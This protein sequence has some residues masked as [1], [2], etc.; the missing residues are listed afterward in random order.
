MMASSAPG[1]AGLIRQGL[2]GTG[3][4]LRGLFRADFRLCPGPLR[5]QISGRIARC[6]GLAGADLRH[7]RAGAVSVLAADAGRHRRSPSDAVRLG[8]QAAARRSEH[9][10]PIAATDSD[11]RTASEH[12]AEKW[13][14]V[15]GKRSCST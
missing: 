6:R 8:R 1:I 13:K 3:G 11:C 14:P 5:D 12:D 2:S 7:P 10:N 4:R 9:K 15:F